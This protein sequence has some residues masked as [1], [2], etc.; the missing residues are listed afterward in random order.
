MANCVSRRPARVAERAFPRFRLWPMAPVVAATLLSG[1]VS[2]DPTADFEQAMTLVQERSG[3]RPDWN[4]PW[5][6][7]IAAWDGV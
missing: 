5:S 2:L 7:D 6:A 3:W 1:C 4:A